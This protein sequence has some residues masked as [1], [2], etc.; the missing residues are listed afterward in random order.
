MSPRRLRR[1]LRADTYS[2]FLRGAQG[3]TTAFVVDQTT[4]IGDLKEK[5]VARKYV[6]PEFWDHRRAIFIKPGRPLP[7][8]SWETM[9]DIGVHAGEHLELRFLRQGGDPSPPVSTAEGED[10][11][12]H[13]G[14]TSC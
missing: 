10:S 13:L 3:G 6:G 2:I 8:G 14:E 12:E 11:S 5:L 9:D 7:L 1:L 4:S